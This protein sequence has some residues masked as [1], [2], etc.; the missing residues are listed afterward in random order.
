MNIIES[1]I[2]DLKEIK[3]KTGSRLSDR[4]I[5]SFMIYGMIMFFFLMV[6]FYYHI[7]LFASQNWDNFEKYGPLTLLLSISWLV[8]PYIIVHSFLIDWS[9]DEKPN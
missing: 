4:L 9:E 2:D 6:V 5:Y 3:P 7:G 1:F 8:T